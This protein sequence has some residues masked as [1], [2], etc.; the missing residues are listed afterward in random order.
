MSCRVIREFSDSQDGYHIYQAGEK[1][2]RDGKLVTDERITELKEK[3]F[4]EEIVIE[5]N[6]EPKPK[7]TA[8]SKKKE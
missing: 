6:T 5:R 2:P 1:F 7:K 8:K 3:S 4:I